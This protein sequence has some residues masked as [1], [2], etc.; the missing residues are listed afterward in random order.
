MREPCEDDMTET[1]RPAT[2]DVAAVA[3][4]IPPHRYTAALAAEIELR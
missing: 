2:A 1:T 4:D 3:E